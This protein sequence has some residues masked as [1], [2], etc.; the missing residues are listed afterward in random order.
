MMLMLIPSGLKYAFREFEAWDLKPLMLSASLQMILHNIQI[1]S[2]IFDSVFH[3]ES[4]S[5]VSG[6]LTSERFS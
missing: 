2:C 5:S 1:G 4:N 6:F 3:N